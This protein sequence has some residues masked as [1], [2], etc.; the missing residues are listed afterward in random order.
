MNGYKLVERYILKYWDAHPMVDD[1]IVVIRKSY[2][3]VEWELTNEVATPKDMFKKNVE[4]LWDWW[5]GEPYVEVLGIIGVNEV[6]VPR[7]NEYVYCGLK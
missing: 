1:V 5:E 4:F 3:G 6:E 7:C 2:D